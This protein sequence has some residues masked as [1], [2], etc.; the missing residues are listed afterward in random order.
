[1]KKVV[2]IFIFLLVGCA[3]DKKSATTWEDV[4]D[5][6]MESINKDIPKIETEILNK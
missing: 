5:S 1:M 3:A 2:L 4:S 6:K